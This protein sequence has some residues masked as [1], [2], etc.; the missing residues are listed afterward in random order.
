[1]FLIGKT[2]NKKI[3]DILDVNIERIDVSNF[4]ELKYLLNLKSDFE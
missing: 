3:D 2:K 1:L 4:D